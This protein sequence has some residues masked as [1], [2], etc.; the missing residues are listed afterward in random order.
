MKTNYGPIQITQDKNINA[1]RIFY[2]HNDIK[3]ANVLS[4][5][6]EPEFT[7]LNISEQKFLSYNKFND[8][9]NQNTTNISIDILNKVNLLLYEF[10]ANKNEYDGIEVIL[11]CNEFPYQNNDI[12][13]IYN[14]FVKILDIKQVNE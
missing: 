10:K 3:D 1:Y 6:V 11:P 13:L 7:R 9:L 2:Y 8:F 4:Y 14:E 5:I 12:E